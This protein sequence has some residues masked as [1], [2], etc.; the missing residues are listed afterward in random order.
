M[1]GQG[2]PPIAIVTEINPRQILQ[3]RDTVVIL[4]KYGPALRIIPFAARHTSEVGRTSPLGNAIA[5]WEADTLV[6]ETTG[7]PA[8]DPVRPYPALTGR[9]R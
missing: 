5:R 1:V 7:L 2:Q 6:I 9:T 3:T 8:R 4:G